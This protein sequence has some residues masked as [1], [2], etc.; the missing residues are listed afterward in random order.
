MTAISKMNKAQLKE[1]LI[2]T[3]RIL[4]MSESSVRFWSKA[5]YNQGERVDQLQLAL[6]A[7]RKEECLWLH[8]T[9]F[10]LGACTLGFLVGLGL[11]IGLTS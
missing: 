7:K 8:S 5:A 3:R 2:D 10:I 4:L 6:D 11:A 9:G 1:A